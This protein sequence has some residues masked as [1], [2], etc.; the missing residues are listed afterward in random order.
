MPFV[1]L[2][3]ERPAAGASV[4][5]ERL[6]APPVSRFLLLILLGCLHWEQATEHQDALQAAFCTQIQGV[7]LC[8]LV[9]TP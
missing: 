6:L 4:E 7:L 1:A 5:A 8:A 9:E 2:V 3:S